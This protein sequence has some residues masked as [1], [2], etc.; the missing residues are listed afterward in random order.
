LRFQI[1]QSILQ[2]LGFT[3]SDKILR[4]CTCGEILGI[5]LIVDTAAFTL[6]IPVE[7]VEIMRSQLAEFLHRQSMSRKEIESLVG[8]L[9]LKY[10]AL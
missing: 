8:S 10:F 7:R 1:A 2:L 6:S 4:P 9:V 3:L 5:I